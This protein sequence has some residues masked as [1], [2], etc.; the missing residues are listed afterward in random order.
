[1]LTAVRASSQSHVS[2]QN[3]D[4]FFFAGRAGVGEKEVRILIKVKTA[5]V[6]NVA[7]YLRAEIYRCFGVTHCRKYSGDK[8]KLGIHGV[9]ST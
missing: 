8:T 7:P 3:F 9:T 6:K 4:F 2:S 5:V 1:V